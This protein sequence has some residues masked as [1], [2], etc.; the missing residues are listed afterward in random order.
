MNRQILNKFS[1][2]PLRK[3]CHSQ[4][5]IAKNNI[6]PHFAGK[7]QK[8]ADV[9]MLFT[10]AKYLGSIHFRSARGGGDCKGGGLGVPLGHEAFTT[11]R[12]IMLCHLLVIEKL[13]RASVSV[14]AMCW[15][16]VHTD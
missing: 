10:R 5:L 9:Q 12:S 13:Q 7:K 6:S 4:N 1:A 3:I 14:A 2:L 16:C 11:E 8:F 15:G